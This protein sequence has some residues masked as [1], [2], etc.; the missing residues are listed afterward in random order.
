MTNIQFNSM[1]REMIPTENKALYM[2]VLHHKEG[3]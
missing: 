1:V 3:N 2:Y